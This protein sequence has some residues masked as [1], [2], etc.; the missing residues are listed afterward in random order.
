MLSELD[1]R[2]ELVPHDVLDS[3]EPSY[4]KSV[5][6]INWPILKCPDFTC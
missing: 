3:G 2:V 6:I 4:S 5:T 1:F